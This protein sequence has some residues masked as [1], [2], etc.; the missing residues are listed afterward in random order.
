MPR[1]VAHTLTCL[2][3]KP[4]ISCH[5]IMEGN[6]PCLV[7]ILAWFLF[8]N[9]GEIVIMFSIDNDSKKCKFYKK[10]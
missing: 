7:T 1:V 2:V 5:D 6:V 10:H 8:L 9:I 4:P 3:I